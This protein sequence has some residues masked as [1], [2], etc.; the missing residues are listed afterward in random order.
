MLTKTQ[1]LL[2]QNF[3]VIKA[4]EFKKLNS[5]EKA[6]LSYFFNIKEHDFLDN[7]LILEKK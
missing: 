3:V 2:K 6:F 4:N 5:L 1:E 7:C